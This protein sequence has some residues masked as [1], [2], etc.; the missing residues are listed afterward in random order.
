MATLSALR[1]N[2]PIRSFYQHLLKKGKVKKV[3]IIA[4][5]RKLLICLNSMVKNNEMWDDYKVT[6]LLQKP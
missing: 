4:C 6:V 5:M 1:S 2:P 3:A